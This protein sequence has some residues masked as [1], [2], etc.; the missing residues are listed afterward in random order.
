MKINLHEP[1]FGEE[2]IQAAV[3][4]MRST[5]VTSGEKV[6]E[7][8][9]LFGPH[10][11]MVNSGSSANLLAI[12][13]ACNPMTP[14]RFCPGDEVIVSALSWS[15]TVWPLVQHGLIPVIVDID[16]DTL[17]IDPEEVRA[18]IG[19]RTRA[20]MPV[21]VYGNPC[22]MN[23]IMDI[24][25]ENNLIV[26]EDCCESLGADVGRH[27]NLA[28]Y[29]FYFSHHITTLEG[30]MVVAKN[31]GDADLLR[32]LRAHGWT[33]E[34]KGPKPHFPGM[35]DKFT[36]INAGYN[37]RASEVNVAIGLIQY[38]KLEKFVASRRKTANRLKEIFKNLSV[39]TQEDNGSS[40]FG[41]PIVTSTPLRE[42]FE[43]NGIETRPIIC[44][45]IARQPGMKLWPHRILGD[46]AYADEVMKY[47]FAIPCHQDMTEADC[48]Y[49][50]G[51]V[52]G[53]YD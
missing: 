2:E 8:E 27:G 26:I 24:A 41:F 10:A 49:I 12:S 9:A 44:G 1:T 28:T 11:V 4:V 15:T 21:H 22:D 5:K 48:D 7:F 51:V 38:P 13:M 20:I 37:L 52:R 50:D 43:N 6:K 35:D 32:I 19:P 36:F 16:P 30:G 18:A 17:N 14:S 34:M 3:D 46:L 29:S 53:F 42:H 33:R 25:L 47:G 45:N 40:W 23:S 39:M 31:E